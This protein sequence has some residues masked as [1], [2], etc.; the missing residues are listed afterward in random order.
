MDHIPEVAEWPNARVC[1]TRGLSP[2]LV[3]IQP[4]GPMTEPVKARKQGSI[5]W[6]V[7]LVSV[8]VLG[9]FVRLRNFNLPPIDGHAM[10]QTDTES[11]AYNLAF[12]NNGILL[13]QNSL[14][15]PSTNSEA[16]FFLEFP[17]YQYII[18]LLYRLFG[19]HIELVRLLNLALFTGAAVSLFLFVRKLFK[20]ESVAF[21]SS[22]FFT[23]APG[24]I[25]FIGHAVHPD[26]F[27]VTLYI[28]SL[29]AFMQWK[30]KRTMW[31]L[32]LS[33]LSLAVS[34]A[35]RP[36]ILIGLPAYL[37]LLW[38]MKSAVWEYA[39]Y[40]CTSPAIYGIWKLWQFR[41]KTA[42]SSW[43]N[44]VLGGREQL[45][46]PDIL[47]KGLILKNIVG[48]VMGKV[49]S[50]F[51]GISILSLLVKRNKPLVFLLLWLAFV[52]LYWYVVPNGNVIHQYYANVYL[53][54]VVI[55]AGYGLSLIFDFTWSKQRIIA[56][57][58]AIPVCMFV[59]Y[60]GY[61]TSQ[62]F[63]SN[64]IPDYQLQIAKE[65]DK[66]IPQNARMIYLAVNNSI[67]FSLYHRTGWMLGYPP[68]DVDSKAAS[69]LSLKKYGA[70]YIVAG[71]DNMDLPLEEL[72][73]IKSKTKLFYS[74]EWLQV[75]KYR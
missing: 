4:S 22:F 43:E 15:R 72:A 12:K 29:A 40:I 55:L 1:K 75:Y 28:I 70:Q 6:K 33:V 20:S 73:I 41:F 60:N 71:K 52:P 65:I 31:A 3:R 42:D 58:I 61:R 14:I 13:P 44:W 59:M 11:V 56:L 63:F 23:F 25:F 54:P 62:Y 8:I 57:G 36:F 34:V 69:I 38:M 32:V 9:V 45:F 50:L 17:M 37:F 47:I 7:L 46:V 10:R 49:T 2:T 53:L 18:S 27:A 39:L 67:P 64:I 66:V 16:Y 35:T 26:V 5:I 30:S 74:S 24:S 21:F 68:V 51:A 19:W 48:E